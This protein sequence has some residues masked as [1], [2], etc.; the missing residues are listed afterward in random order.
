MPPATIPPPRLEPPATPYRPLMWLAAATALGAATDYSLT[1]DHAPIAA[2]W[3][4]GASVVAI[5]LAAIARRRAGFILGSA[6]VLAAAFGVGGAWQH[7]RW[8]YFPANDLGLFAREDPQPACV[9][10]LLVERV[11]IS[12]PASR[13]PLRAIPARTFSEATVEVL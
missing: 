13:S 12:P 9:D 3:W 1:D 5:A 4:W 6:L 10:V 2:G 11:K 7:W 8:N